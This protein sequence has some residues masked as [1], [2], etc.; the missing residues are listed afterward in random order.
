MKCEIKWT[1]TDP[2]TGER[3]WLRAV[4]FASEWQF[5]YRKQRRDVRWRGLKPTRAMWETVLDNLRR[6][7][8]RRQGVSIEDV[9]KVERVLREWREPPRLDEEE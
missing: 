6:R 9:T 4:K 2:R 8:P 5:S 7:Y 1:D 3:R